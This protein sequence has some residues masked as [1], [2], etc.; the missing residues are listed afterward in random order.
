VNS[1]A[2]ILAG[3]RSSRMGTDKAMLEIG[4]KTLLDRAI[5]TAK[6]VSKT[7]ALLGDK[8]RLRPF[9]WVIED[10]Y[11]GQGP[12][13]G[14]HAALSSNAHS[15]FNL[16]LAVDMPS[17]T[18]DLLRFLLHTAE[19]SNA[20]VTVPC[21]GGHVQTLC[22]V[23]R[24]GFRQVAEEALAGGHN[25]IEPLYK[26]VRA[27]IIDEDELAAAGFSSSIFEN[28]NTPDEWRKL[29]HKLKATHG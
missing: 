4:E 9:G 10:I 21:A 18:P 5:R 14:I 22:S 23:Y 19:E 17:L 28:V 11:P 6:R 27:R 8:E 12:L 24:P 15:E 29:Q 3:G 13:A 25:K 20:A 16:L 7:V 2:F 1:T 26:K